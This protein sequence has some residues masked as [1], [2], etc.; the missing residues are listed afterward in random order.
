MSWDE[1]KWKHRI[2]RITKS[3]TDKKRCRKKSLVEKEVKT[4]LVI[5]KLETGVKTNPNQNKAVKYNKKKHK[6][7]KYQDNPSKMILTHSFK[8]IKSEKDVKQ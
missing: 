3:E 1:A 8:W 5:R 7:N 6:T 2:Q 4:R